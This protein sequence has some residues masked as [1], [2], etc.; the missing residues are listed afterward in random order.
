MEDNQYIAERMALIKKAESREAFS[1]SMVSKLNDRTTIL[2]HLIHLSELIL[3]RLNN[4]TVQCI[5][6]TNSGK[7]TVFDQ[8]L[9]DSLNKQIAERE[10]II[11]VARSS[12][13]GIVAA[14]RVEYVYDLAGK[15]EAAQNKLYDV[16]EG[17]GH[18]LGDALH[19]RANQGNEAKA[20]NSPKYLARM[21]L[22][23][24]VEAQHKAIL[25]DLKP[26]LEALEA[27]LDHA[28]KDLG[29]ALVRV[30]QPRNVV[31]PAPDEGLQEGS[32]RIPISDFYAKKPTKNAAIK[33]LR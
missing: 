19:D 14:G 11:D 13:E 23:A 1:E 4:E 8:P 5:R 27:I 25:E 22:L 32:R 28:E 24:K 3:R 16:E 31:Q 26:K 21:A 20:R 6:I 12:L 17:R 15:I 7:I 18:A 2:V 29:F 10:R 9:L 30:Q 33:N